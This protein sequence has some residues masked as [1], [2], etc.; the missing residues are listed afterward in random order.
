[1]TTVSRGNE[2]PIARILAYFHRHKVFHISQ[3]YL[4]WVYNRLT[5]GDCA[6]ME[7]YFRDYVRAHI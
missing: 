4:P 7:E 3:K 1:M 5:L 2:F 6:M